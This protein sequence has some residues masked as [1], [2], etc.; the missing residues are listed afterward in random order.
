MKGFKFH[1]IDAGIKHGNQADLGIIFSEKPATLAAVFTKNKIIA[2]PVILGKE[3][4]KQGVC[5][6]VLVNSGNA[7]CFTGEKGLKDAIDSSNM[8]AKA[9][10]ISSEF[11]IV[12]S[13]G[14]IGLPLPM[15]NFE[16]GIPLLIKEIDSGNIDNF[17]KAILTTD[18]TTKKVIT[19]GVIKGKGFTITGV[20]KGSGMIKPDMATMLAFI[21]TD[22]NIS[23][24]VL[25]P[26]LHKSCDSSFNRICVDGDTSTNDTVICLANGMSQA[27][28]ED[29][30][31]IVIFQKSLDHVLFDLSK[32]IVKDGEGATKLA[33][34]IVKGAQNPKDAFMAAQTIADSNLVK[35]ALFGEDPN[36]GRIVAAAGRSG[37]QVVMEQIDLK[38][39]DVL[40]VDKGQW[41]GKDAEIKANLVL[42]NNEYEI[43]LDLNIGNFEDY[44]LFCDF[45]QEYVTIN[46]NYRS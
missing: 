6:A 23:S 42:K 33:K 34:I 9:F 38:F 20:A 18:K 32:K 46:A 4:L 44:F 29:I 45:S 11:V 5:Q 3:K 40:I 24:S 1:G 41:C 36:W 39:D 37:A 43:I 25:Q 14:V 22:I 21:C 17:A 30:D 13:T 12:S 31:D 16:K 2:A 10:G 7:N 15:E 8:V 28:V 35:T 27:F 26:I 19:K